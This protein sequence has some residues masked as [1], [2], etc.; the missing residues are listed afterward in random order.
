MWSTWTV[1]QLSHS[2]TLWLYCGAEEASPFLLQIYF[3]LKIEFPTLK[4]ATATCTFTVAN[5]YFAVGCF[6]L[7]YSQVSWITKS[8]SDRNTLSRHIYFFLNE[9]YY[10]MQ[11]MGRNQQWCYIILQT[12]T[13]DILPS[14]VYWTALTYTASRSN[15]GW[16]SIIK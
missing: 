13:N 4:F 2:L 6:N 1:E 8:I 12:S 7:N 16:R 9:T 11:H 15:S 3:E 5:E 14:K 10:S